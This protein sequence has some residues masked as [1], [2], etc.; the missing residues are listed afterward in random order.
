LKNPRPL[1]I[2]VATLIAFLPA[3]LQFIRNEGG[4]IPMV[5]CICITSLLIV[6]AISSESEV[7]PAALPLAFA[8]CFS[9]KLEGV[10]FTA[11]TCF[12]LI[13]FCLRRGWL[14]NKALW[15]SVAVAAACVLPYII[16]RLIKPVPHPEDAWLHAGMAVAPH[17]LLHRFAQMWFLNVFARFFSAEFF[18]WQAVNDHLQW[19]GQ[20]HGLSSFINPQLSVLPWFLLVVLVTTVVFKP[21]SRMPIAVLSAVIVAVF[22]ILSFVIACLKLDDLSDGIDFACGIVGRYYYPFFTA[23]FLAIASFWF[24]NGNEPVRQQDLQPEKVASQLAPQNPKR[25]Q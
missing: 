8:V 23:G 25:R 2:A 22:T 11:L 6:K 1:P 15:K 3:T 9:T 4:T 20:W 14:G 17:S 19:I 13:P 5:F 7:V 18:H 12:A 21:Q 24:A 10:V 16:Y